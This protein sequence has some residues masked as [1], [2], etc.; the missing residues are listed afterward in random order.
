MSIKLNELGEKKIVNRII[1]HI[2][3]DSRLVGGMGHDSAFLKIEISRDELLLLNTDRSGINVAYSLGL[4]DAECLGDFAVSHAVSDILAGGGDV[5]AVTLALL[6]PEHLEIDFVEKVVEGANKAARRYGATIVCGDTKENPKF[7]A[8][9]TAIG[10][11]KEGHQL[12]RSGARVGDLIVV[13]GELG[14]M[15]AGV[16]AYKKSLELNASEQSVFRD[17]LRK[18]RPPF[19]LTREVAKEKIAN[20]CMD[21]SDGLSG[22]I[23]SICS[24]S[25]VGAVIDKHSVP[26]STYV[27]KVAN[28]I[29]T[30]PFTF[31]LGSG[32]WRHVYAVSPQNWKAFLEVAE[33]AGETPRVI[34]NFTEDKKVYLKDGD[35]KYVLK[36]I[37]NDRFGGTGMSFFQRI[38]NGLSFKEE[39]KNI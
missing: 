10:K 4:S 28:M 34:G 8:V 35:R 1:S 13:S 3:Q 38:F 5:I 21:N 24:N 23:Y 19:P 7:A 11:C 20:A 37:E 29:G 2:D 32:D 14:T 31:A 9:V 30:D 15:A 16:L 26:I 39:N 17:S 6:L 25:N 36:R 33:L 22:T 12:L 27:K 18:Q